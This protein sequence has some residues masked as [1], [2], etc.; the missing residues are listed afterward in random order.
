MPAPAPATVPGSAWCRIG[1]TRSSGSWGSHTS[2]RTAGQST[3]G[4][5]S[6]G[7]A[8]AQIL[9]R[10][11]GRRA[12]GA[13]RLLEQLVVEHVP[14]EQLALVLASL[15]ELGQRAHALHDR[16]RLEERP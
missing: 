11:G 7:E 14:A 9:G 1:R 4:C 12:V 3:G 8:V 6:G 10:R 13:G 5:R 2:T 16:G 15:G